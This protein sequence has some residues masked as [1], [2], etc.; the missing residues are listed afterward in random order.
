MSRLYEFTASST[1]GRV[2]N[3]AVANGFTAQTY[4]RALAPLLADFRV[5]SAHMRPLWGDVAPES[6]RDWRQL[7]DDLLAVLEHITDQPMIGIGHSVGGVVTMYAAIKRPERFSHLILID[8]TMLRP[9]YLWGIRL[10]RALGRAHRMPF[11]QAA[12]RRR[13]EWPS[14][15]VAYQHLKDKPLFRRWQPDV[16]QAYIDSGLRSNGHGVTL[17]ITPEWEAQIFKTVAADV[18][19]LPQQIRIPTLVIRG[20]TTDVF[21]DSSARRFLARKPDAWIETVRGAG[22]LVPQEQ[23][24]AVGALIRAFITA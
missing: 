4:A 10:Y 12:L 6:L 18:W 17:T 1:A 19:S 21:S 15:E 9:A 16:M 22:H 11:V 3:L 7:G 23:P 20:E 24:E 14:A 5:V 13:R 2:V 8:P